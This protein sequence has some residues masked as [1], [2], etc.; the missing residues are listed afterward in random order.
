[1]AGA[2]IIHN[3][4]NETGFASNGSFDHVLMLKF[5]ETQVYPKGI[6]AVQYNAGTSTAPV[7]PTA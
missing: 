1:L 6:I 2:E 4:P 7:T 3:G 5:P